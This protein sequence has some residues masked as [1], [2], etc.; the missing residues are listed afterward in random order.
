VSKNYLIGIDIGTMGTKTAIF[1]TDGNIVS[2]AF[3][4]SNLIR[5]K[6]GI[7]EQDPD[8]IYN[9]VM[10]TI[11]QVVK[12]SGIYPREI[13]GIGLDGQ[14]AGIL[15]ID[16]DWNAVTHYDSWLDTRCEPYIQTMK[17]KAGDEVLA[18]TGC[19]VTYAHG[20]KILW[21]QKEK[22]DIFSKIDKFVVPT[23]YIAGR[24]TGLKGKDAYIDYTQLHFSGF[25]DVQK[26]SWSETITKCFNIPAEKL[27][28]IIH[29]WKIIGELTSKCADECGLIAGIPVVA[30]AGDQPAGSL[31]AGIVRKGQIF[32]VAGTA[33]VFSCCVNAFKPDIEN[34]TII[35]SRSVLPDLWIPLAYINGGG[36]CLRWFRDEFAGK[37]CWNENTTTA[38]YEVLN[39]EAEKVPAGAEGLLFLPHLGGRVCP[40]DQNIR[41][42]W[43]GFTWSHTPAHFYRAIMEG[44][45]FE[46]AYYLSILKALFEDIQL[47]EVRV[48][49]G[50]AKSKL[51]NTI[52]ADVL[53][54]PYLPL[55]KPDIA[56][57]GSAV[58]AGYGVG[59]YRN[60]ESAVEN[61][62]PHGDVIIPNT[63]RH[64]LYKEYLDAY[65]GLF[66][67][68]RGTFQKL[69][70][71]SN[72]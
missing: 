18:I 35:F 53:G 63:E 38:R 17:E 43:V 33:S 2:D 40:N 67:N 55:A 42:A 31:G 37:N 24:M 9:S 54:I 6:L 22:P 45:A 70:H 41:G 50:G 26:L 28:N 60:F 20:P 51:F 61:A 15:G 11:R 23:T 19:P 39:E 69:T 14:M 48:I 13:A 34:K 5:P 57:F 7:V 59:I 30:G 58:I 44:I 64:N 72:G 21:W 16:K 10:N 29:P 1:S 36:L 56:V 3:E 8:E 4:D 62:I 46:Y 52:K 27:P 47:A 66:D 25:G 32:D 49:G 68:L 12:K 71:A 65:I